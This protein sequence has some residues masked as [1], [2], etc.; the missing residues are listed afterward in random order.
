MLHQ[1]NRAFLSFAKHHKYWFRLEVLYL[2]L[3]LKNYE[4]SDYDDWQIPEG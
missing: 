4:L 1:T 2:P 3:Y